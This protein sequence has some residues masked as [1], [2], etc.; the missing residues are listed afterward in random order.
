MATPNPSL[1][2]K[3][4]TEEAFNFYKSVFGGE[5]QSL[6]RWKEMPGSKFTGDDANL[7]MHIALPIGKSCVL[8]G[9]DPPR[10]MWDSIKDGN[11]FN[12]SLECESKEEATKLYNGLVA[13]GGKPHPQM[14]L[15]DSF[16]GSW[17]GMLTDKFGIQWMV[18]YQYP[19]K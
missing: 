12:I 16:W 5:F 14:P 19:K 10:A 2:F 7:I 18:N 6:M 13:D 3:G 15:G 4:N 1:T 9:G 17:F 11:N 8:M